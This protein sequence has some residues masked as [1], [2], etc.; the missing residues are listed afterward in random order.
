MKKP[1]TKRATLA[2]PL[3]AALV[4][5]ACGVED[6]P[7]PGEAE[8]PDA[9]G[10]QVSILR[11]G[12]EKKIEQPKPEALEITIGFDEGGAKLSEKAVSQLSQALES[13]QYRDGGRIMLRGHSDAGGSDSANLRISRARAEAVGAWLVEHGTD[14]ARITVIGFGEQN[15]IRPNAKPDGTPDKAARAANRRVEMTIL[16]AAQAE[17]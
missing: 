5:A 16:P 11:P 4:L 12:V 14:Q 6:A 7:A 2:F 15:P 9:S 10:P 1:A 17:Q 8:L 3:L 13:S